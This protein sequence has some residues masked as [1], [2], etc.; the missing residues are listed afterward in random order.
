MEVSDLRFEN[1][2]NLPL[3]YIK[4]RLHTNFEVPISIM[5]FSDPLLRQDSYF[6][7]PL[8]RDYI[9]PYSWLLPFKLSS[10][11]TFLQDQ[12]TPTQFIR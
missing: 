7:P 2:Q 9:K 10:T 12:G 5:G 8:Y 1:F 6:V 11:E 3:G 4:R